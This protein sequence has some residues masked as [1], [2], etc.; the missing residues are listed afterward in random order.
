MVKRGRANLLSDLITGEF[1][2]N[3]LLACR[4][5]DTE[6]TGCDDCRGADSHVNGTCACGA[7]KVDQTAGCGAAD[8]RVIH[9]NDGLAV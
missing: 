5:V 6:I 8:N 1:A 2:C 3:Q 7:D 4:H 9:K